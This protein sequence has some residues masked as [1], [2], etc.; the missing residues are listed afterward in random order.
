MEAP[1]SGSTQLTTRHFKHTMSK[2]T[3]PTEIKKYKFRI[4]YLRHFVDLFDANKGFNLNK[5]KY[6]AF[7]QE[8]MR[9][10]DNYQT[11][12]KVTPPDQILTREQGYLV[13]QYYNLLFPPYI[14]SQNF[15]ILRRYT[16]GFKASDGYDLRHILRLTRYLQKGVTVKAGRA[17]MR[18]VGLSRKKMQRAIELSRMI[19][20]LSARPH[21]VIRRFKGDKLRKLQEAAQHP[22]FPPE[23]KVA[24]MPAIEDEPMKIRFTKKDLVVAEQAG[25][26]RVISSFDMNALI[27]DPIAE[28]ER[29]FAL[30]PEEKFSTYNIQAGEYE[31]YKVQRGGGDYAGDL[32]SLVK[33]ALFYMNKYSSQ[34]YDP[35]DPNSS[36]FGNWLFGL[37]G[38]QADSRKAL[39]QYIITVTKERKRKKTANEIA[40]KKTAIKRRR[41]QKLLQRPKHSRSSRGGLTKRGK[42]K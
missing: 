14:F 2:K 17:A 34:S 4:Q 20:A 35:S 38:Y 26:Q 6:V 3:T 9:T 18:S 15:K 29:A 22:E 10:V 7:Q 11:F 21:K 23:L 27:K 37:V 32:K 25:R 5:L 42:K 33:K 1:L 24:F 8:S 30:F 40:R 12:L 36:Y 41:E 13:N 16:N 31:V 28:I 39:G 19:H